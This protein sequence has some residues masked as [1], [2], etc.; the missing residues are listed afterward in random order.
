MTEWLLNKENVIFSNCISRRKYRN[1]NSIYLT[2][3][4]ILL[5]LHY[6]LYCLSLNG[7]TNGLILNKNLIQKLWYLKENKGKQ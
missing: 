5:K 1:K 2:I 3:V 7:T 4:K 6:L